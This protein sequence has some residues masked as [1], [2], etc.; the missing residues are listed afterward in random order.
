MIQFYDFMERKHA[1]LSDFSWCFVRV[2]VET[3]FWNVEKDNVEHEQNLLLTRH[4]LFQ[5][6]LKAPKV[7]NR[8]S[9]EKAFILTKHF[10]SFFLFLEKSISCFLFLW[11]LFKAFLLILSW[12]FFF[13]FIINFLDKLFKNYFMKLLKSFSILFQH[14]SKLLSKLFSYFCNVI[15][16][17]LFF[18]CWQKKLL[19]SFQI[20]K[21][22]LQKKCGLTNNSSVLWGFIMK[23]RLCFKL[24]KLFMKRNLLI[25]RKFSR[26][27]EAFKLCR[28]FIKSLFWCFKVNIY[29]WLCISRHFILQAHVERHL[30]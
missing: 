30:N 15:C 16:S 27:F 11:K 17:K 25:T 23:H 7:D 24:L 20:L 10:Q 3:V 14:F 19:E 22:N 1:S 13:S 12:K 21:A 28:K 18:N 26:L 4:I 9:F 6:L 2:F 29:I 5:T 8:K